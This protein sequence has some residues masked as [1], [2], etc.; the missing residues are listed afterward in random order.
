MLIKTICSFYLMKVLSIIQ[1]RMESARLPGKVLMKIQGKSILEHIVDFLKYSELTDRIIVATTKLPQDDKIEELLNGIGIDCYR[2]SSED[3]VGRFYECAKFFK[4]DLI[5]RL[6]A[7]DPLVDPLLVDEVIKL[8]KK[9]GCDYASNLLPRTFPYGYSSGEALTFNILKK[10]HETEKDPLGREHVTRHILQHPD[11]YDIK[12]VLAPPGLERPH[13]RL[14][15][16]YMEDFQLMSEIFS[17]LYNPNSFI[18]YRSLVELLDANE[19]LLEIN[20]KYH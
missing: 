18:E 12:N 15:V 8:C 20:E 9:T 1:A 5:V 6:T 13:W 4:G 14:T 3:V 11:L 19:H 10:L 2:G 7:D 17:R 16:D